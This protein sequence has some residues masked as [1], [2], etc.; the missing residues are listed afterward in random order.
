M[1]YTTRDR[2]RTRTRQHSRQAQ[3]H[4]NNPNNGAVRKPSLLTKGQVTDAIAYDER[5]MY[6]PGM[7]SRIQEKVGAPKTGYP[8][9]ETV[10][11]VAAWQKAHKLTVDGKVGPGTLGM[12]GFGKDRV[13]PGLVRL[14]FYPG[15]FTVKDPYKQQGPIGILVV[16][17][18]GKIVDAFVARGGPEGTHNDRGREQSR[19]EPGTYKLGRTERHTTTLW[20]MSILP[21]GTR[22]REGEGGIVEYRRPGSKKWRPVNGPDSKLKF[23]YWNGKQLV[24][25]SL[26]DPQA[27]KMISPYFFKD[28]KVK[29][30]WTQNDFGAYSWRMG[31]TGM[32]IHTTSGDEQGYEKGRR[33]PNLTI[34][35]GCV[36]LRPIDRDEMM[37]KGYLAGGVQIIVH[38]YGKKPPMEKP[39]ERV[40]DYIQEKYNAQ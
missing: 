11:A 36:H 14:E 6:S 31:N 29:E 39:V 17:V 3:E 15:A 13:S 20:P 33:D 5:R 1:D 8:D 40:A 10:Q 37:D 21:W 38:P 7:W 32:F 16:K 27:W 30:R 4:Q 22:L 23:R 28:N 12:M 18:R 19:T 34:S 24:Y 35:H 26:S 2:E 9:N 25:K